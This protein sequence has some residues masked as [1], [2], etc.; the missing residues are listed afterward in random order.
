[1]L[2]ESLYTN[3]EL[4]TEALN[5]YT[6]AFKEAMKTTNLLE[7]ERLTGIADILD[8]LNQSLCILSKDPRGYDLLMSWYNQCSH[9]H[10][11]NDVHLFLNEIKNKFFNDSLA[12][13]R[14]AKNYQYRGGLELLTGIAVLITSLVVFSLLLSLSVLLNPVIAAP[15]FLFTCVLVPIFA[16]ALINYGIENLAAKKTLT[17]MLET[18]PSRRG[19]FK[20]APRDLSE[21]FNTNATPVA[22]APL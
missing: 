6:L 5:D 15:V 1:M 4:M 12:I 18:D 11:G 16:N 17:K 14:I 21:M 8:N 3:V 9:K 22:Q 2:S 13:K 10:Q 20:D 19:F 7:Q